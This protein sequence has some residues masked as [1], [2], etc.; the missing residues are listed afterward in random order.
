MDM[1]DYTAILMW[2]L[3][4]FVLLSGFVWSV[5][6][7][8]YLVRWHR[9]ARDRREGLPECVDKGH[10]YEF[11]YITH[12]AGG[13]SK[14]PFFAINQRCRRCGYK[15]RIYVDQGKDARY[16]ELTKAALIMGVD[17]G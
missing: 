12:I 5:R 17:S 1:N 2:V 15:R 8:Y 4:G 7:L 9:R 13:E 11:V 6:C 14:A 3:V 16:D 10:W